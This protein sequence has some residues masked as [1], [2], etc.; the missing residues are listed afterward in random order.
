MCE[1]TVVL[2]HVDL[3]RWKPTA[4]FGEFAPAS[5]LPPEAPIDAFTHFRE[6]ELFFH[7]RKIKKEKCNF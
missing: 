4:N 5:S 6:K 1:F 2:T 7:I 3:H